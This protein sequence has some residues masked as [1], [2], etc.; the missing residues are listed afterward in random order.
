MA[1]YRVVLL[2]QTAYVSDAV[3]R[4][5]ETWVRGGGRLA[6]TGDLPGFDET[7]QPRAKPAF[8][9][10]LY[11]AAQRDD[12]KVVSLGQ[13]RLAWAREIER[14]APIPEEERKLLY[15]SSTALHEAVEKLPAA[16]PPV[17]RPLRGL[18]D[19]LLGERLA[20]TDRADLPGL[21]ATC[22]WRREGAGGWCSQYR[23]WWC[24]WPS[25]LRWVEVCPHDRPVLVLLG[26]YS[27]CL[28]AVPWVSIKIRTR[29][30]VQGGPHVTGDKNMGFCL[31]GC[32]LLYGR[33]IYPHPSQQR[34]RP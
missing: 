23:R 2:P 6:L 10:L 5:L 30:Y 28:K 21:R 33:H 17:E 7:C 27:A 1:R 3:L 16:L 19:S 18:L 14:L 32:T 4:A 8:A 24:T 25:R 13:G 15:L 20:W 9:D 12:L 22:Y 34:R 26:H 29:K 11:R 31:D